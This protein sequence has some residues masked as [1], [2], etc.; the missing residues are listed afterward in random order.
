MTV[1]SE[2]ILD[3]PRPESPDREAPVA[4]LPL[5]GPPSTQLGIKPANKRRRRTITRLKWAAAGLITVAVIA[6]LAV[7]WMPKPIRVDLAVATRGPLRITVNEDGRTRV[8]NRYVVSAPLAGTLIRPTLRAGDTVRRGQVV[9]R[10]VPAALPLLDSRARAEAEARVTAALAGRDQVL[11][12]V[13]RA[14]AEYL[15]ARREAE[16]RDALFGGGAI[17]AEE[18]EQAQLAAETARQERLRAGSGLEAAE[19]EVEV[20]RAAMIQVTSG[21]RRERFDLAAPVTGRVLRILQESEVVA[22]PGT[23]LLEIGDP[24]TLEVVV[25]VLSADAVGIQPGAEVAVG[26]WGGE[27]V[28]PGRVRRLEPSAFTRLSALGVEEQ[29]VNVIIDPDTRDARWK[30]LSDGYRVETRIL[31]WQAADVLRVPAGAIFRHRD[32]WAVYLTAGGR[33]RLRAVQLG[34]R[35]D[36]EAQV[37]AGLEPGDSVVVYPGDNVIDGVRVAPR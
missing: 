31:V 35:N 22:Q 3:Q 18:L 27:A 15:V 29:R 14:E 23:P 26:Q 17:A 10:L 25:D 20:A 4:P 8:R 28:L 30:E 37:L 1:I 36:T 33:A 6:G 32:S 7:A 19:A 12:L 16:R 13:G 34:R 21:V 11:A 2:K 24:A 9:A 5:P